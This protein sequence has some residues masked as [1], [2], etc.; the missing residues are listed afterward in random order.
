M[1]SVFNKVL[2][3]CILFI[4]C[5]NVCFAQKED[6]DSLSLKPFFAG[7][8][9]AFFTPETRWGFGAAGVYNFFPGEHKSTRPSQLQIGGAYTLNKQLLSFCFYNIFLDDDKHNLY[10]ELA[11]YDYFYQYYG[12]GNQTNFSDEELYGASY[13]RLQFNYLRKLKNKLYLG[14]FYHFDHYKITE[15][16]DDGL[17]VNSNVVGKE[18][19]TISRIGLLARYDGRD[20][21]FYPTKGIFAT[22]ELGAN[23]GF[24]G[25]SS[26]Y[27]VLTLDVS[28]YRAIKRQV[29]ALNFWSGQQYGDIPF[30]ELLSLGG[31]KKGRGIIK[32]RFRDKQVLLFQ[33]EYRFPIYKRF[34]GTAFSSAGNVFNMMRGV[35]QDPWKINYGFGLRFL[36]DKKNKTNLRV[37]FALGSDRSAFY[38]TVNEAF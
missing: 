19:S 4:A 35:L 27:Q 14:G 8:P 5:A 15:V 38:F 13:P 11:Y 25:A 32:G 17:L 12:I 31:S 24:L 33:A 37:D 3:L 9:I 21:I 2:P 34:S 16:I 36:L 22:V 1:L 7:Y 28:Y 23:V 20:N 26:D 29:I 6:I 18:G 10:G 30:Q